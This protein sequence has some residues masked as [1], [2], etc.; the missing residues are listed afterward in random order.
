MSRPKMK[1]VKKTIALDK[2]HLYAL[3][4]IARATE[5]IANKAQPPSKKNVAYKCFCLSRVRCADGRTYS[6]SLGSGE[7]YATGL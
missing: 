7:N 6:I 3:K 1:K 5:E 2:Q 4:A